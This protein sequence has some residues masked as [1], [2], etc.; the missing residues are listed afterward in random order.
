MEQLPKIDTRPRV[1]NAGYKAPIFTETSREMRA[2]TFF[3]TADELVQ[4]FRK[5][6]IMK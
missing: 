5:M 3:M 4:F 6:K 2:N 1:N